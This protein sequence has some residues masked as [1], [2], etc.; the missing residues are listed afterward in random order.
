MCG[1]DLIESDVQNSDL[2]ADAISRHP[3]VL[4]LNARTMTGAVKHGGWVGICGGVA[5]DLFCAMLLARP[6]ANDLSMTSREIRL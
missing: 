4:R 6:G 1:F 5:G 3:R 2:A